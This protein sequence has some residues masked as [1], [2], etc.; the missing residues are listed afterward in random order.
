MRQSMFPIVFRVHFGAGL[1]DP[2]GGAPTLWLERS[3][4]C[5]EPELY[6]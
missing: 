6:Q 2:G 4:L 3:N 1:G 5:P